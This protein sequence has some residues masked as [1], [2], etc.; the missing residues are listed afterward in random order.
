RSA[1]RP[2]AAP[3][4][5]WPSCGDDRAARRAARARAGGPRRRCA[6]RGARLF[7]RRVAAAGAR[8]G[9]GGGA[10]RRSVAL[11][12]PDRRPLAR[13]PG[14]SLAFVCRPANPTLQHEP[15]HALA[16]LIQTAPDTLFVADEA[17]LPMF[18]GV[19]PMPRLPNLAI[20]RSMTKLFALPGLRLGYL[21]A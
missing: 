16:R 20:L 7:H 2:R 6:R 12:A 10:L 14:P 18:D 5:G 17:Y 3:R 1:K 13:A 8:A 4:S 19:E 15:L 9:A 11:S 21:L